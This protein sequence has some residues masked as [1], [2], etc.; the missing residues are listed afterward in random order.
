MNRVLIALL[1]LSA[2][3]T[4]CGTSSPPD[5][6]SLDATTDAAA[7][8]APTCDVL[9]DRLM[10]TEAHARQ[11]TTVGAPVL[12][13]YVKGQGMSTASVIVSHTFEVKEPLEASGPTA[14]TAIRMYG[15]VQYHPDAT[16]AL[17][18]SRTIDAETARRAHPNAMHR[19]ALPGLPFLLYVTPDEGGLRV[20]RYVPVHDAE[21]ARA[22]DALI[23]SGQCM[24][25]GGA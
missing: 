20:E 21:E 9:Y 24:P 5:T 18:L 19:S 25:W 16:Y 15:N 3:M 4:A 8:E 22:M 2:L 11:M 14:G 23:R 1:L 7:V 12:T 13:E 6:R 17:L 10:L